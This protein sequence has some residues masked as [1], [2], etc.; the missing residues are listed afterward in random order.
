[1]IRLSFNLSRNERQIFFTRTTN[2]VDLVDQDKI[3]SVSIQ[4]KKA[5]V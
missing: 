5:R 2:N 3:S 4:R 1:M